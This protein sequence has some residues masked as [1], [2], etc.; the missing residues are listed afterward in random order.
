[1]SN[2]LL[3]RRAALGL[4]VTALVPGTGP[5]A[6][7]VDPASMPAQPGDVL[8]FAAGARAGAVIGA[9][10]LRPGDPPVF[11][12]AMD[13]NQR[14]ARNR[15]R[16]G[17]ILLAR[18]RADTARETESEFAADGIVAFSAICT[19]AGCAVTG[20]KPA[21]GYFLCPCH[22]SVY[23]PAA[24]GRVVAGPAPRPLPTLQLRVDGEVL[25]VAAGFTQRIGGYTSRTD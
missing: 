23:D 1:M 19:H 12:W 20:W 6:A 17:Q 18:L 24:G 16:I 22:G 5:S 13:P 9:G 25:R 14:I 11:A 21:E 10:D 2:P 4:G 8:V 3:Y 7:P 15:S